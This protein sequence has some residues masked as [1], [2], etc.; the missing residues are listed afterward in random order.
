M[1]GFAPFFLSNHLMVSAHWALGWEYLA[2]R[3][4]EAYADP[5]TGEEFSGSY[6]RTEDTRYGVTT[7]CGRGGS[8]LFVTGVDA[9]TG[10]TIVE[11]WL[12]GEEDGGFHVEWPVANTSLGEPAP[13]SSPTLELVGA[14]AQAYVPIADRPRGNIRRISIYQSALLDPIVNMSCDP[15]GRYLLCLTEAHDVVQLDLT[16][17]PVG[18]ATLATAS[19]TPA[20]T[21]MVSVQ[22]LQHPMDGRIGKLSP[23]GFDV[24]A[25][26]VVLSDVLNDGLFE[27]VEVLSKSAYVARGYAD[28]LAWSDDFMHYTFTEVP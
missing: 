7:A 2:V 19:G 15:E 21:D 11:R 17:S 25:N 26:H 6:V 27:S 23:T 13:L 20:L 24:N 18:V 3:V 1:E 12:L 8:E 14:P 9:A 4:G 28:P 10:E 22:L 5:V 16:T